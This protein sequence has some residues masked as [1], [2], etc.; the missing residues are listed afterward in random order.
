MDVRVKHSNRVTAYLFIG[1]LC[2]PVTHPSWYV[3]TAHM[4]FTALAIASAHSELWFYYRKDGLNK[5]ATLMGSVLGIIGFLVS[6]IGNAY[7][8]GVGEVLAATP[9][10]AH[11]LGTNK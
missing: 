2:T 5:W 11:V 9:I 7:T 8:I 3:E 4:I 6:I 1:V 10:I